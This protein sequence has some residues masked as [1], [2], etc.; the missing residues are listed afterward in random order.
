MQTSIDWLS[1]RSETSPEL[2]IR[3]GSKSFAL[4]SLFLPEKCRAQALLL[5]QWCRNCDDAI[6]EAPDIAEAKKRLVRLENRPKAGPVLS[7][8]EWLDAWQR[9]EFVAGM[10]MDVEGREYD[11]LDELEQYCF[12][13]AG[14]VGLM[15]CPLLGADMDVAPPHAVSLG[16]AM[17]LTNIARDIQADARMGRVYI[18]RGLQRSGHL[19]AATLATRPELAYEAVRSIL[20]RSDELYE[21]G[22]QGIV[23][24]PWRTSFAIAVAGKVYQRI[25]HKLL[26]AARKSP[27]T[28]FRQRTVV[29]LPEKILA[30]GSAV[31]LVLRVRICS[32]LSPPETRQQ[33]TTTRSPGY[34]GPLQARPEI[35]PR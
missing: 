33:Q 21:T 28:A 30:I 22:F 8:P 15:M 18:P 6:D 35:Q 31:W 14:V 26:R 2:A 23:Y 29:S 19:D 7:G 17:Q 16:N 10:R 9:S 25:G 12:R 11:T 20:K 1:T 27:M 32:R 24:L 3:Q 13:V 34:L 4:A 5:Y